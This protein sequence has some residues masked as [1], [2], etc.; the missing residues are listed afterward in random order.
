MAI[1]KKGA[2]IV[3]LGDWLELAPPR[4]K[5][6]WKEGRSAMEVARRWLASM[7]ALPPEIVA[8]LRSNPVFDTVTEWSAEPEVRLRFDDYPGEPRNTDLLVKAT[9]RRGRYIIAVEAKA[10]EPFSETVA[11]ALAASLERRIT[12]G[13]SNGIA[14]VEQLAAALLGPLKEGQRSVGHLRYQL[15]TAT[16]GALA[17]AEEDGVNRAVLAIH[18]F[19]TTETEDEA[20]ATNAKDLNV[21]VR[22]LSR[23]AISEVKPGTLYGPIVL[24]PVSGTKREVQFFVGKAVHRMR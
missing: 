22:R 19:I 5:E 23:G 24:S 21:F 13:R 16:G 6:Q 11:D 17:A 4:R 3:T 2:P 15:L 18:E 12:E 9:D 7:P 14:R 1:V 10:D 8:L 20:H